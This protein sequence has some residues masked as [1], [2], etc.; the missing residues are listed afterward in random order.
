MFKY[1]FS[2]FFFFFFSLLIIGVSSI[3]FFRPSFSSISSFSRESL[4]RLDDY[5][6]KPFYTVNT[7]INDLK[8]LSSALSENKTLSLKVSQL[9][10]ENQLLKHYEKENLELNKIL[11]SKVDSPFSRVSKVIVR[12]PQSWSDSLILSNGSKEGLHEKMLVTSGG[13]LVGRVSNVTKSS[14]HVDLLTCG[15]VFNLPI[16]IVDKKH[17]IYG[18]LKRFNTDSQLMIASEFN[19]NETI[20]VGSKV[21]TSG[22]DGESVSD[23]AVGMVVTIKESDDKLKRQVEIELYA[24]FSSIDYVDVLGDK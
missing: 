12:T 17:S 13:F 22:L 8:K 5:I 11:N 14:S 16:K 2:R 4:S 23:V 1:R 24:D 7:S 15:Q 20:S 6:A 3:I 9:E 10:M 21:Y 19:S 18:N